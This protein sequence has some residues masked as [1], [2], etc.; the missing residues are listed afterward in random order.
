ME[1]TILDQIKDGLS[2]L[3]GALYPD[4][5]E[6]F[7]YR[8]VW[9]SLF[10]FLA[11]LAGILA[12]TLVMKLIPKLRRY[13]FVV[14]G[15]AVIGFLVLGA[16]GPSDMRRADEWVEG[17]IVRLTTRTEETGDRGAPAKATNPPSSLTDLISSGA[18][19]EPTQGMQG[20]NLLSGG[21]Q[22][23]VAS[24]GFLEIKVRDIL[25]PYVGQTVTVSFEIKPDKDLSVLVYPYQDSG[26]SIAGQMRYSLKAG[27]YTPVT[28]TTTVRDFGQIENRTTGGVG[29]FNDGRNSFTVRRIKIELGDRA[30]PFS[31][32]PQDPLAGQ[33]LLAGYG[34]ERTTINGVLLVPVQEALAPYVGLT[35]NISFD[36]KCVDARNISL[37]AYR[38]QGISVA[39]DARHTQAVPAKGTYTRFSYATTVKEYSSYSGGM[40]AFMDDAIVKKS[41]SIRHL[42]IELGEDTTGWSPAPG[43]E[44]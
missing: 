3:M 31:L 41:F 29:I 26:V 2:R 32:A 1:R 15:L 42:K 13:A 4:L 20:V 8:I 10:P 23:R 9:Q 5:A 44:D 28:M 33:N 14:G 34:Q 38:D 7:N 22:E 39:F 12:V 40:L 27:V 16:A 6:K 43:D 19:V 24:A 21:L 37:C 25:A 36:I 11:L 18:L 30:T 17:Q 35:V